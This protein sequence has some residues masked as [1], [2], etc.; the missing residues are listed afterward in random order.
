MSDSG[1]VMPKGL[2]QTSAPIIISFDVDEA[3][4]G[5]VFTQAQIAMQLNVLD[6]EV[7]VCTGTNLDISPPD[8]QAGVDTRV[9]GSLS[10]TSRS[11]IGD[12]ADNNVIASARD[13]I[14]AAGFV[15]GG[16]AFQEISPETP[17]S[18]A[19][20]YVGIIA[21]NDF[22]VQVQG[23]GNLA[24]RGVSGR[25]YG[26]RARASASIYSALVQSE[27]LSS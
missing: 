24:A 9:R 18:N 11:T 1:K 5:N 13:D 6:R 14:K 7:F 10:T 2:K 26:V 16:V 19:L 8:A 20:D 21:T 27:I 15:D 12:L 17:T 22:F 4:P 25:M 23:V 3:A